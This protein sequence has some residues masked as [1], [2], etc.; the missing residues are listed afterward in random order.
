MISLNLKG[1]AANIFPVNKSCI[2][3]SIVKV[4]VCLSVNLKIVNRANS[5]P[6]G[7]TSQ[8]KNNRFPSNNSKG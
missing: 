2:L 4:L 3:I 7:R 6:R 5:N 1:S 8:M